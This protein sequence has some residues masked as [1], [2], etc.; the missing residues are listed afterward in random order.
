MPPLVNS[1]WEISQ[2]FCYTPSS[3][4]KLRS[5]D[6]DLMR[7]GGRGREREESV[8]SLENLHP[9]QNYGLQRL[10][11]GM[12][13]NLYIVWNWVWTVKLHKDCKVISKR[14]NTGTWLLDID[15]Q[16]GNNWLLAHLNNILF[17][18]S[19]F[20]VESANIIDITWRMCKHG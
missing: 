12:Q 17:N 16:H 5:R 8:R 4:G 15:H 3:F 14:A 2:S 11:F 9:Q 1:V 13:Y 7:G 6:P 10:L 20:M 19:C 18:F